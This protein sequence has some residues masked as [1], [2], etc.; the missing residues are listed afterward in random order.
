MSTYYKI[1]DKDLI[2]RQDSM[3]DCYIYDADK[4]G[5]KPDDEHILMD[6]IIGYD[7]DG[8]GSSDMLFK[9]E[10]ITEEEANQIIKS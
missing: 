9:V 5:W 1:L 2:G 8:I 4:G 6:R 7:G 10:E 3:F